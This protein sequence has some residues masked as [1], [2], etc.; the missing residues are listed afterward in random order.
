MANRFPFPPEIPLLHAALLCGILLFSA[1]S[2]F[3]QDLGRITGSFQTDAQIYFA[4]SVINAPEVDEKF[5]SNS[6]V[7]LIY[8]RGNISAGLRFEAYLNPLLGFEPRQDY[9]GVGIP[10]RFA[11]YTGDK[12]EITAG[13]IYDQFGNGLVL[14]AYQEWTLGIDNSIDGIQVKFKPVPGLYIKGLAGKQRDNRFDKGDGI[15]RAADAEVFLN[16]LIPSLADSKTKLS[17][18]GSFVSRF[19]KDL[20]PTLKLPQNV[21]ASAA[22]FQ[23]NSGG[24]SLSSEFAY[25]VN[26]PSTTNGKVYN[27]GT[28]AYLSGGYSRKGL[29]ITFSAK[30]IDNFD[31]RSD[32]TGVLTE[33]QLSFLPPTTKIHTYRLPTLYPYATQP[34]G[35]IGGQID[36]I[37]TIPKNTTL[38]GK[39]GT[40]IYVNY[41]RIHGLDTTHNA[42]G[43]TYESSILWDPDKLY[44]QDFNIEINKKWSKKLRT[45]FSYIFLTYNKDII[46][47]GTPN[48]GYGTLK[49]HIAMVEVQYSPKRKHSVRAEFQHNFVVDQKD[50]GHWAFLLVEYSISPHWYFSVFDEYNYGNLH[51]EDRHHFYNGSVSYV[52]GSNRV[53][54]GY[55][56]QREGLLCVGGICRVV[57]SSN[58]ITLS[59][60]STF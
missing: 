39:Y 44:F 59:I 19:Q 45:T 21:A 35:E 4:D 41:S 31:F 20:D 52:F 6:Y 16:E 58:G 33:L 15:V 24:F 7:Q 25:K 2:A 42:G 47:F 34:N 54:I 3:S 53:A 11:T 12:I 51:V 10:Y 37:Y 22:R 27:Q 28:A 48:A 29:G 9:E 43:F 46:E 55:A 40:Q 57:P 60:S 14:R 36:I 5:L 8:Q 17:I 1:S 49:S 13:N 38:G 56:R 30:R 50:K 18:G 26:D 32:R 23:L